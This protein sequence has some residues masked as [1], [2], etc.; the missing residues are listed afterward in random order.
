[1]L[2][3]T[4]KQMP[5]YYYTVTTVYCQQ[6]VFIKNLFCADHYRPLCTLSSLINR[7]LVGIFY[8]YPHLHM[9]KLKP[10]EFKQLA[11]GYTACKSCTWI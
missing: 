8:Y 10:S 3:V 9:R 5:F 11:Y 1:M 4:Q 2:F 7:P 6:L